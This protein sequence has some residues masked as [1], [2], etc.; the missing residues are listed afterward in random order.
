MAAVG[1]ACA[2]VIFGIIAAVLNSDRNRTSPAP[3]EEQGEQI[4]LEEHQVSSVK[5]LSFGPLSIKNTDGYVSV[6]EFSQMLDKLY[7]D[8]Y[9]L[10]DIYSIGQTDENGN[11]VFDGTVDVPEGKKP[12]V[13]MQRDVSY[14]ISRQTEDFARRLV[15]DSNGFIRAE[16]SDSGDQASMG[17]CDL[18]P[19]LETFIREHPDFSYNG[20]RGILGLTGYNGILGYRTS[21]YLG[22]E[23]DNPYG[24]FDTDNQVQAMQSVLETLVNSGWR[25]ASNGFGYRISYGSEYSLVEKDAGKWKDQV[26]NLIGGTDILMLP[27]QT[28]IGS[29]A[30]YDENNTKYTLMRGLGF[31]IYLTAEDETPGFV[32]ARDEYLRIAVTE[33]NTYS[34]FEAVFTEGS[35]KEAAPEEETEEGDAA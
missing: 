14:P 8:S 9:V 21:S 34:E 22:S 30:P 32:L 12:L 27:R 15:V 10:V 26:G 33:I 11:M 6:K 16:Y 19:V 7:A 31:R 25:F 17:D 24:T 35:E 2:L 3:A 20:A 28:D 5:F 29:W 1:A 18:V 23:E 13:I 4:V